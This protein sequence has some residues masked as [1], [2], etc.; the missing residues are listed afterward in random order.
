MCVCVVG[1]CKCCV[2]YY[3]WNLVASCASTSPRSYKFCLALAPSGAWIH[4]HVKLGM[5]ADMEVVKLSLEVEGK[6]CIRT[7]CICVSVMLGDS[8][9]RLGFL[10]R[11]AESRVNYGCSVGGSKRSPCPV[12]SACVGRGARL[13]SLTCAGA[14]HACSWDIFSS[15]EFEAVT[16]R[17]ARAGHISR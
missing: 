6:M 13:D 14:W 9:L 2:C 8:S 10:A 3:K 11:G 17:W 1:V 7:A 15:S 12:V 5:I 4:T 16:G